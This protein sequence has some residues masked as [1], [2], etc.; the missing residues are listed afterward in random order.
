[1]DINKVKGYYNIANKAGYVIFGSDNLKDY[2]HKLYLVIYREDSENTINKIVNRLKATVETI[3][4]NVVD[5]NSITSSEKIKLFAIKN[6][7]LS[8]QIIK[9]LRSN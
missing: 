7:G 1:M 2:T 8:E 3:K 6:K 5:F 9:L 4:L